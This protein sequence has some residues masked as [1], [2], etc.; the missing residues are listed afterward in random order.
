MQVGL[1]SNSNNQ[2]SHYKYVMTGTLWLE[3]CVSNIKC[4]KDSLHTMN[5]YVQWVLVCC[6][7]CIVCT[8]S[9]STKVKKFFLNGKFHKIVSFYVLN[10]SLDILNLLCFERFLLFGIQDWL[11]LILVLYGVKT[12]LETPSFNP[13]IPGRCAHPYTVGFPY[14]VHF[15]H[16][17]NVLITDYEYASVRSHWLR[18]SS[19]CKSVLM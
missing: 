4:A 6:A 18:I 17:W 13:N 10:N 11:Q 9:L 5:F 12:C 2:T 15:S 1:P 7:V 3:W 8:H 16:N 19:V 14:K